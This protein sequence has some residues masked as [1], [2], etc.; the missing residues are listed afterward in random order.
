MER[1]AWETEPQSD[2]KLDQRDAFAYSS[3]RSLLLCWM[4]PGE[5]EIGTSLLI[6]F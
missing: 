5:G 1:S 3:R 2:G 6:F 4:V